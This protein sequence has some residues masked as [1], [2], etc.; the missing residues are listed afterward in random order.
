VGQRPG[1]A[2]D[3]ERVGLHVASI[4]ACVEERSSLRTDL[5]FIAR[6]H[7]SFKYVVQPHAAYSTDND[8]A[9][10]ARR[11]PNV[12]PATNACS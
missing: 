6:I 4:L 11:L 7:D 9:V 8:N 12:S 1:S 5:R 3:K 2:T 10:L